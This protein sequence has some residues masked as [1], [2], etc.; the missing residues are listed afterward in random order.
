M[1]SFNIKRQVPNDI[2]THNQF[3]KPDNLKS[4]D[5]LNIINQWTEKNKMLINQKKSKTMIFNFTQNYQFTTRF[6]LNCVSLEVIPKTKL[7]GVIIQND[8]KWD[9]N[10][11]SLVKRANARMVIWQKLSEFG[12]PRE[13]MKITYISYI[14][15]ILEQ[16]CVVWQSSHTTE[17]KE[18]LTRV[19]KTSC[20]IILKNRY[21]SYEKALES[22]DLEDLNERRDKL[23]KLFARKAAK[24]SN[25]HFKLIE[26]PYTMK[27]R[28]PKTYQVTHCNTERLKMSA[29]PQMQRMLNEIHQEDK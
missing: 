1:A 20:R 12:A 8:L 16:S 21:N 15:S 10:T 13:D 27:L 28:N 5:N 9:E 11:A 23:C 26:N 25:P 18:D 6:Q 14:R 4:Q 29:V 19:Q 22:L 24:S 3:I 7:L 2:P 17:N